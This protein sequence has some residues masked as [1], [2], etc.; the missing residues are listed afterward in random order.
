MQFLQSQNTMQITKAVP[1]AFN[2]NF[3]FFIDF[4]ATTFYESLN[5]KSYI[6]GL[7]LAMDN[8]DMDKKDLIQIVLNFWP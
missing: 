7:S 2:S 6:A 5:N 1:L 3:I 4:S 8:Y